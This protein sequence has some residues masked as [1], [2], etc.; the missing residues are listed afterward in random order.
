MRAQILNYTLKSF[1]NNKDII[2]S[3]LFVLSS[4]SNFRLIYAGQHFELY[5]VELST[6][7]EFP[8][9]STMMVRQLDL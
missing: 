3:L 7:F 1:C 9:V 2:S 4:Q 6:T 5:Y 8:S